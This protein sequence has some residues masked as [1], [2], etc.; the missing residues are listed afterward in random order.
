MKELNY[1]QGNDIPLPSFFLIG[2]IRSVNYVDIDA[3]K[4]IT[5]DSDQVQDMLNKNADAVGARFVDD[6]ESAQ[7]K[8][9][10]MSMSRC[11]DVLAVRVAELVKTQGNVAFKSLDFDS[12]GFENKVK[13][14]EEERFLRMDIFKKDAEKH[15]GM[16]DFSDEL[17]AAIHI[18]AWDDGHSSGLQEVISSYDDYV[19]IADIALKR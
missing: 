2:F 10:P 19:D 4:E 14:L 3:V 7:F 13:S 6:S 8:S 16:E 5:L 12:D 9:I 18:K 1:Y 15:F 11:K 17:K